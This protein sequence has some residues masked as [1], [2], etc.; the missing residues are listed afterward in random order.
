MAC[1]GAAFWQTPT[2]QW[3]LAQGIANQIF[4]AALSAEVAS[5]ATNHLLP[6]GAILTQALKG[7]HTQVSANQFPK[8]RNTWVCMHGVSIL[9]I[10]HH[11]G[12]PRC[13]RQVKLPEGVRT[14]TRLP[15]ESLLRGWAR[16]PH[17]P[18]DYGRALASVVCQA[19]QKEKDKSKTTRKTRT[20]RQDREN[21]SPNLRKGKS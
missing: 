3:H 9:P 8:M 4:K 13:S 20:R 11:S 7:T 2:V 15:P 6:P 12:V 17:G 10:G 19:Q 16:L 1:R 18:Q 21:S 14:Q 5:N